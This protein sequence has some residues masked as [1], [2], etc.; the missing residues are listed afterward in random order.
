MGEAECGY[1]DEEDAEIE[2]V[3]LV[4]LEQIFSITAKFCPNRFHGRTVIDSK[5]G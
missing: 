2:I 3:D 5:T 4:F 1:D